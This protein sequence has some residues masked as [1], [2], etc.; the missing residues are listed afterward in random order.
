MATRDEMLRK[1]TARLGALLGEA[2]EP[3]TEL[4]RAGMDSMRFVDLFV[5]VERE[6]GID[7]IS[8]DLRREDLQTPAALADALARNPNAES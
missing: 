2:V 4:E 5:F 7:L 8:S 3:E 1:L 6:F